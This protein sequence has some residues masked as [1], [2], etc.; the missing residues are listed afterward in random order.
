MSGSVNKVILIGHA[1]ADPKIVTGG[2]GNR[3]ASFSI[4][5]SETWKNKSGE[6]Q[7]KTSWHNIVVLS[8]PLVK[9][10]ESY[11][12]KGDRLYVEGSIFTRKWQDQSGADKYT[13]EIVLKGFA[14]RLTMLESRSPAGQPSSE[15]QKPVG[16]QTLR[17]S[18]R[19]EARD[20]I[21]F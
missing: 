6:K 2:T 14:D 7:K 15:P 12:R 21:P 3:L 5:T 18:Y 4:A 19:D 17:G 10:C 8:E 13:T 9:F 20:E 11:V 1:G 16:G